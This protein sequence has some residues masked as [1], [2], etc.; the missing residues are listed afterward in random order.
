MSSYQW[1]VCNCTAWVNFTTMAAVGS[2]RIEM[3]LSD[4][5]KVVAHPLT[6]CLRDP[7]IARAK[8]RGCRPKVRREAPAST[9]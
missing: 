1:I 8:P 5:R 9:A 4:R 3:G 6:P 7:D 2:R